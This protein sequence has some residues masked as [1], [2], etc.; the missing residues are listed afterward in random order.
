M[1]VFTSTSVTVQIV[2]PMQTG[3]RHMASFLQPIITIITI[4]T[5][6]RSQISI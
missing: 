1:G 2:T 3:I 5:I 6:V 4:I